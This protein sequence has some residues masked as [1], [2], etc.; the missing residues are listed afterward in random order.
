MGKGISIRRFAE[1]WSRRTTIRGSQNNLRSAAR[2]RIRTSNVLTS[3]N[4]MWRNT[5]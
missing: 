3:V 5:E 1:N 2:E 4:G